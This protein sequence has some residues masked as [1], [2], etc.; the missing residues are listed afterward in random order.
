VEV[1][2]VD[3]IRGR[4]FA[5]QL[6]EQRSPLGRS[7]PQLEDATVRLAGV[8]EGLALPEVDLEESL[9]PARVREA[10][11]L[12]LAVV[13]DVRGLVDQEVVESARAFSAA[14]RGTSSSRRAGG[15]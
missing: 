14:N 7:A 10:D 12:A 9:A 1:C 6:R 5:L 3:A 15:V 11:R 4:G 8:R 2:G 13:E